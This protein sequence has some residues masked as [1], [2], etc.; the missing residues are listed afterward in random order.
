MTDW[1]ADRM[2]DCMANCAPCA[3]SGLG[4]DTSGFSLSK[5]IA[6]QIASWS[7]TGQDILK[8]ENLPRGVYTQ[9]GPYGT[10]TYIQPA[11]TSQNV[12]AATG[13]TLAA[14]ASPGM[15]LIL[16]GGAALLLVFLL[17]RR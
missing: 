13:G 2:A 16:L 12:F 7:K 14:Q 11:G 8:A 17:A 6:D 10:T 5:F 3:G 9:T 1:M 4:D 15:G